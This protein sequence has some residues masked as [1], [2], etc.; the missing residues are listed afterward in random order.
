MRYSWH[1]GNT[2]VRNPARIK[3]G[4]EAFYNSQYHGNLDSKE[5]ENGFAH[6]LNDLAIVNLKD[7]D[8]NQDKSSVGRKWRSCFDQLGFIT[9][10]HSPTDEIIKNA[11]I[12]GKFTK[13]D[14]IKNY[15]LT[16]N[17]IRLISSDNVFVQQEAMLRALLAYELPSIVETSYDFNTF[18]P[19]V[20]MLQIIKELG[21][22]G[23]KGLNK[24]ETCIVTSFNSHKDVSNVVNKITIYRERRNQ[25]I[26]NKN[27]FDQQYLALM[28]PDE[29]EKNG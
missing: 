13:L 23:L 16:P 4:L 22:R 26:G 8:T 20:F 25:S 9:Y 27:K 19:F 2:T 5:K 29:T 15:M 21:Q 11:I 7:G 3:D 12:K 28:Y 14:I 10:K 18:K 6:L 1:F 17:G 24:F